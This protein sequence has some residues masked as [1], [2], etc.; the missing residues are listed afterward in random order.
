MRGNVPEYELRAPCELEG[1]LRLVEQGWRPLAGGT[2]LMVLLE[3]G[4]L[5][6]RRFAGLWRIRAL[7]GV[8]ECADAVAIGALT[9]FAGIR[10]SDVLQREFPLLVEASAGIGGVANQNRATIGGNL[11]NASPAADASPA[12]LVYDAELELMSTR[13]SRRVPYHRFHLGYKQMDLA[14]DEIIA[15]IHL[16]RGKAGWRQ[17]WR[18]VAARSAQAITKVSLAAAARVEGGVITDVRVAYGAVAP[19]PLRCLRTEAVLRGVAL[20]VIPPLPDEVAPI[21]DVRSTAR[22]RQAVA[23]NLMG[24]FLDSLE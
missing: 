18:K 11:A 10:G 7:R 14:G 12:L 5:A 1:A 20:G 6:G 9:T 2:D 17:Y 4:R 3:S 21:D 13:G 24:E 15:R 22:Y 23:R 19:Y 16:R 8:E